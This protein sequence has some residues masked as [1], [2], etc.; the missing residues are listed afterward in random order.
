M[1]KL[2]AILSILVLAGCSHSIEIDFYRIPRTAVYVPF[3]TI[4]DWDAFG[5][6]GALQ[7]RR[8]IRE[9]NQPAGY[10]YSV[11]TATGWGGVLLVM[12]VYST[13]RAYDLSCPVER[14]QNVRVRINSETN[15]AECPECHSTYDVFLLNGALA[16]APTSGPALISGYG[17]RNYRVLLGVDGRDRLI[18]Q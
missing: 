4:G 3:T 12:D 7:S 8:F 11:Q 14:Q 18:S 6:G 5:V 16:G 13:A 1:R 2:I 15:L 17:M 10:T 9:Q